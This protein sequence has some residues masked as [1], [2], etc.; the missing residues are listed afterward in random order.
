MLGACAPA[1]AGKPLVRYTISDRSWVTTGA[2]P[3]YPFDGILATL[4]DSGGAGRVAVYGCASDGDRTLTTS[5]CPGTD[6]NAGEA[7]EGW[8]YTGPNTV[9][10]SVSAVPLY[11]CPPLSAGSHPVPNVSTQSD[12]E[13]AVGVDPSN[14]VVLGYAPAPT[15]TL[16]RWLVPTGNVLNEWDTINP[17][18]ATGA[19][20]VIA[21]GYPLTA[22]GANRA[23]LLG[24]DEQ[25][26]NHTLVL[27][28]ATC[29]SGTD[30]QVDGWGPVFDNTSADEGWIY[31]ARP[32][33]IATTP[34]YG[35]GDAT[36][37][38]AVSVH[39]CPDPTEPALLGYLPVAPAGSPPPGP[40]LPPDGDHD[41]IKDTAD[42]CPKRVAGSYD[43]DHDG[44]PG[45]Y[46]IMRGVVAV[47]RWSIPLRGV[48]L[49]TLAITHVPAGGTVRLTCHSCHVTEHHRARGTKG[50]KTVRL[51][52]LE[53]RTLRAGQT[54]TITVT[55]PGFIGVLLR[56]QARPHGPSTRD[57]LRVNGHPFRRTTRCLPAGSR[58]SALRC[59]TRP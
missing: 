12:C 27:T 38:H 23:A 47:A 33:G 15:A 35:C 19:R 9:P 29:N 18:S 55:A 41:G 24:C 31:V 6:T 32:A 57:R 53:N 39:A 44:C 50:T 28:D 43:R 7:P 40:G 20:R 37:L 49:Q 51:H 10:A 45:P 4:L 22:G 3:A 36:G 46:R 16:N 52:R 48:R 13:G 8:L 54:F 58:H 1:A 25:G 5:E 14:K 30:A 11:V 34:L 26:G 21:L 17:V 56:F 42:H 59:P 2:A